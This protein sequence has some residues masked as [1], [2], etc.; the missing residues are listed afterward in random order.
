M[1]EDRPILLVEDS[2][3]DAKLFERAVKRSGIERHVHWLRDGLEAIEYLT[4]AEQSS[5]LGHPLPI[6]IVLDLKMPKVSGLELLGWL[7]LHTEFRSIPTLVLSGSDLEEDKVRAHNLGASSFTVKPID[8]KDLDDFVKI[9]QDYWIT[10]VK[11]G[12][13]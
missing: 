6:V 3:T 4:G 13:D 9:I 11:R 5:D 7:S 2:P 10:S 8:F 1:K 12:S